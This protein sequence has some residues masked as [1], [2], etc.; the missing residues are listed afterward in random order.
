VQEHLGA[1]PLTLTRAIIPS[2]YMDHTTLKTTMVFAPTLV[3]K[4][5]GS[6]I[7]ERVGVLFGTGH[8]LGKVR[9][10]FNRAAGPK[11]SNYSGDR[12][13][14][15]FSSTSNSTLAE[16]YKAHNK[17]ITS[18][19]IEAQVCRA[20]INTYLEFQ[21]PPVAYRVG[22]FAAAIAELPQDSSLTGWHI[23]TSEM[24]ARLQQKAPPKAKLGTAEK[25]KPANAAY[26]S[27]TESSKAT[28]RATFQQDYL[29]LRQKDGSEL[30]IRR[31]SVN[32][33][34]FRVVDGQPIVRTTTGEEVTLSTTPQEL[35]EAVRG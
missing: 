10:Y 16:F 35:I 17:N 9:L 5:V 18:L 25:P 22:A 12:K 24:S 34:V 13:V 4:L 7:G 26:A 19:D 3:A 29:V 27:V 33:D 14:V 31:A 28:P 8:N 32:I 6:K 11:I 2:G 15:Q 30:W 23:Y 21:I 20:G 1:I